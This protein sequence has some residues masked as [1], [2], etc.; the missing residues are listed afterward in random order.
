MVLKFW[1]EICNLNDIWKNHYTSF[2]PHFFMLLTGSISTDK[3]LNL[4]FAPCLLF[5]DYSYAPCARVGQEM[6]AT[7]YREIHGLPV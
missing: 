6:E 1:D 3:I 4:I 2:A 5:L 7:T